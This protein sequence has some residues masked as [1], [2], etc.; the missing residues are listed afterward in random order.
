M[1]ADRFGKVAVLMGGL[2]AEREVSLNSGQAVLEALRRKGVDAHGI[3][4]DHAV[5]D[6]LAAGGFDRVFIALHGR[7]GEDGS[8]QGALAALGI[9]GSGSGVLGSAL[10][11][12]KQR[13]K[14]A[15]EAAA[16]MALDNACRAAGLLHGRGVGAGGRVAILCRN[17]AEFFEILFA[18]AKLG[19]VLVPLNWRMPARELLPLVEEAAPTVLLFGEEDAGVTLDGNA[20]DFYVE[21]LDDPEDPTRYRFRGEWRDLERVEETIAVP[22]RPFQP[23]PSST[24]NSSNGGPAAAGPRWN[25]NACSP[26]SDRRSNSSSTRA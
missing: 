4:A 16:N 21:T 19:A 1:S 25:S 22:S 6:K 12:D 17:R 9:P 26:R 14:A 10:A 8:M 24:S 2:S 3:D 20:Q 15:F 23:A 5:L 13:S 18:C 7:G 11:M